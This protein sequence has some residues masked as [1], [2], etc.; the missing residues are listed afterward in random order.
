MKSETLANI[1]ASIEF[2]MMDFDKNKTVKAKRL[3]K[4]LNS[5]LGEEDNDYLFSQM[6]RNQQED[7]NSDLEREIYGS[8]NDGFVMEDEENGI[9]G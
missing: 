8:K 4:K 6:L 9:W 1:K 7:I 2:E 5:R 3:I